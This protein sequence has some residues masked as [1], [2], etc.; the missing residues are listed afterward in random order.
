MCTFLIPYRRSIF[1]FRIIRRP[2]YLLLRK[3]LIKSDSSTILTLS[4]REDWQFL[5]AT[6]YYNEWSTLDIFGPLNSVPCNFLSFKIFCKITTSRYSVKSRWFFKLSHSQLLRSKI[7]SIIVVINH[8]AM[9]PLFLFHHVIDSE[10]SL[11]IKLIIHRIK[12]NRRYWPLKFKLWINYIS[13]APTLVHS[14]CDERYSRSSGISTE[15]W[16]RN[17]VRDIIYSLFFLETFA[18]TRKLGI[19]TFEGNIHAYRVF[20]QS[21]YRDIVHTRYNYNIM[22]YE[23]STQ[24]ASGISGI[25]SEWHW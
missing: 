14:E 24:L 9:I 10:T 23:T 16:S 11:L 5:S 15:T 18:N 2:S 25:Y 19:R 20:V 8:T 7:I 22:R 6:E 13:Y 3:C 4:W 21:P 12:S 17:F 1:I